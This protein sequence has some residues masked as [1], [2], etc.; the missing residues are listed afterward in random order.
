MK[1]NKLLT[2]VFPW[3]FTVFGCIF[4]SVGLWIFI[5]T[6][7]FVRLS[8]T[9]VGIV[10]ELRPKDT[11]TFAPTIEY[12]V[13]NKTFTFYSSAGSNPPAFSHGQQVTMYYNPEDPN[14]AKI[15]SFFYLWGESGI[16]MLIGSVIMIIGVG[17]LYNKTKKK[18]IYADLKIHGKRIDA[19]VIGQGEGSIKVNGK[20]PFVLQ[21]QWQDPVTKKYTY[22]KARICGLIL[23][24]M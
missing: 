23:C 19:Y 18:N 9:T 14:V 10:T 16:P 17:I 7:Q 21:A 24:R 4:F 5:A 3:F 12:S 20:N 1:K 22:L 8:G 13:G 15:N 11:G 2:S 6:Y